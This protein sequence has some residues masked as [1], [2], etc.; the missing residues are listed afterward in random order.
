MGLTESIVREVI[1]PLI[2]NT[3]MVPLLGVDDR[4]AANVTANDA[5]ARLRRIVE[6]L[7]AERKYP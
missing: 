2:A 4:F 3:T 1:F 5:K 6:T 7:D